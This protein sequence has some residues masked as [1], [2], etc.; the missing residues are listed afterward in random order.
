ML[1][2]GSDGL[3]DEFFSCE[4]RVRPRVRVGRF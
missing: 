3:G 2:D 4:L 1:V